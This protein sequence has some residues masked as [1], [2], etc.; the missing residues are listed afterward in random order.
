MLDEDGGG[1]VRAFD[2][3]TDL[4]H[5]REHVFDMIESRDQV[6]RSGW[7]GF[8]LQICP[9]LIVGGDRIALVDETSGWSDG[10]R[11]HGAKTDVDGVGED[12]RCALQEDDTVGQSYRVTRRT[13]DSSP[14]WR[15]NCQMFRSRQPT[16]VQWG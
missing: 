9:D 8:R 2:A 13:L 10:F 14:T 12:V 16:D 7:V 11:R 6:A 5:V 3:L 1:P 4:D 15:A